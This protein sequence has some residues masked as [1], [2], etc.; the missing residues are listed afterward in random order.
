MKS[1]SDDWVLEADALIRR[2]QRGEDVEAL[3]ELLPPQAV[4]R[5][6]AIL[7]GDFGAGSPSETGIGSERDD[8]SRFGD[9][10]LVRALGHGGQAVVYEATDTRNGR[11][12]ALKV[13]TNAW[14]VDSNCVK[15]LQREAE[16]MGRVKHPGICE[17]YE[18]GSASG[19]AWIAMRYVEGVSLADQLAAPAKPI[20][21]TSTQATASPNSV[22]ATLRLIQKVAEVLHVAHEAGIVHRD[23]KPANIMVTPEGDPVV[24]DFGLAAIVDSEASRLT[25]TGDTIGTPAYMS[26][27]QLTHDPQGLDR[28]TDV[29][30]LGV[31]LYQCLTGARP[32]DAPTRDG[33]YRAIVHDDAPSLRRRN[34]SVSKE[35]ARVVDAALAKDRRYRYQSANALAI[36]LGR[37]HDGRRPFIRP[38]SLWHRSKTFVRRS[39]FGAAAIALVLAITIAALTQLG[40]AWRSSVELA[41]D[42]WN[43]TRLDQARDALKKIPPFAV[44]LFGGA[45]LHD[46]ALRLADDAP[47]NSLAAVADYQRQQLHHK[48]MLAAATALRVQGPC[49]DALDLAY[50]E[51]CLD[52]CT[53]VDVPREEMEPILAAGARLFTERHVADQDEESR[54]SGALQTAK[55]LL[56]RFKREGTDPFREQRRQVITMLTV[57]GTFDDIPPL[58]ESTRTL[59]I[60]DDE[61]RLALIVALKIVY[62][63]HRLRVRAD[64]CVDSI[65]SQLWVQIIESS[66]PTTI[67]D[68]TP[69]I[70]V[71]LAASH[72]MQAMCLYRRDVLLVSGA[73]LTE[74][75]LA[76]LRSLSMTGKFGPSAF[77]LLAAARDPELRAVLKR[78]T[79]LDVKVGSHTWSIPAS[80]PITLHD[81]GHVHTWGLAMRLLDG[82]VPL[83]EGPYTDLRSHLA[84]IFSSTLGQAANTQI[85]NGIAHAELELRGERETSVLDPDTMLGAV[86]QA[87]TRPTRLDVTTGLDDRDVDTLKSFAGWVITS[88]GVQL[89]GKALGASHVF[90]SLNSDEPLPF[91]RFYRFDES[92]VELQFRWPAPVPDS[93]HLRLILQHERG[94]RA[95][96]PDRGK[97]DIEV[98]FNG[99]NVDRNVVSVQRHDPIRQTIILPDSWTE[100]PEHTI[101]IR[102]HPTTTTT[103]RLYRAYLVIE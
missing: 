23:V 52:R 1:D 47:E 39:P 7:A 74:E 82:A 92:S 97:V 46:L 69:S 86:K 58:L 96:Q 9:Y 48:A 17:V 36:D 27:E 77:T 83:P 10:R 43:R 35:L 78:L 50:F 81:S 6:R 59:N 11:R 90:G 16:L 93:K 38:P 30:S 73:L 103:Y 25:L 67:Q 18:V 56:S 66:N 51:K 61:R 85:N 41:S 2:G 62:R 91:L 88:G 101:T 89:Y 57:L 12:V 100:R 87:D 95:V 94:Q 54:W 70:Q 8:T 24:L 75:Q 72:L 63:E 42:A 19:T 28:R 49:H 3:I 34:P 5:V 15:R 44:R 20:D 13:L 22:A 33:M 98:S 79:T 14:S 45:E 71:A 99:Q 21:G 26:P 37:V 80:G 32:F 65:S 29:W 64:K 40:L 53:R 68:I 55:Q 102:L 31:V 60:A 84:P 4:R 76:A